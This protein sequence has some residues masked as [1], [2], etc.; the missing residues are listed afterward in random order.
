MK[1]KKKIIIAVAIAMALITAI[2][3]VSLFFLG[4]GV[5]ASKAE[6]TVDAPFFDATINASEIVKIELYQDTV[7]GTK[8]NATEF[9]GVMTG[10]CRNAEFGMY[11]SCVHK[12]NTTC[13]AV[14]KNDGFYTVFNLEN[15]EKTIELYEKLL[16]LYQLK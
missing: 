8:I 9:L 2:L 4:V 7:Y 3:L 15:E 11:F 6:L 13:I 1:R 14:L 10:S 12:S 16:T 5:T